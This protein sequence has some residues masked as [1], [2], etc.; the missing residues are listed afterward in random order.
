MLKHNGELYY[1]LSED[2]YNALA[3]AESALNALSQLCWTENS[4]SSVTLENMGDLIAY[5]A[6]SLAA[7]IRDVLNLSR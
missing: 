2:S 4:G 7:V 3:R 5:P 6:E 1:P